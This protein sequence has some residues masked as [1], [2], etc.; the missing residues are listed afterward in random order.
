M[1]SDP[2][3]YV[4]IFLLSAPGNVRNLRDPQKPET[5]QDVCT[6]AF[7]AQRMETFGNLYVKKMCVS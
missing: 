7:N 6:N 1:G 2:E 5:K 4:M 3:E